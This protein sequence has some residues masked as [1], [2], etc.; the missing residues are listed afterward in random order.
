M[1][2]GES[3]KTI[4]KMPKPVAAVEGKTAAYRIL[5]GVISAITEC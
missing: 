2:S 1:L 4:Y 3:L 5:F